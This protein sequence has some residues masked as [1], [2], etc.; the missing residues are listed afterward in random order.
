MPD[1]HATRYE[2]RP[3][4]RPKGSVSTWAPCSIGAGGDPPSGPPL[5]GAQISRLIALEAANR[6]RF[7]R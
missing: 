3:L 4:P 1:Q 2:G 5:S 7:G 6:A